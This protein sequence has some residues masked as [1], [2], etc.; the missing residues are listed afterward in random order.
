MNSKKNTRNE[1]KDMEVGLQMLADIKSKYGIK[2]IQAVRF[3]KDS[4]VADKMGDVKMNMD[5]H[6]WDGE[7]KNGVYFEN[8]N[9]SAS[10]KS[11]ISFSLKFQDTSDEKLE[12]LKEGVICSTSFFDD[13]KVYPGFIMVGNT[14]NVGDLLEMSYNPATRKSCQVSM[15]RCL[16]HGF[17]IV[18]WEYD[19]K[20]TWDIITT[21]FPCLGT[22]MSIDDIY[23]KRDLKN[24]V[25]DMM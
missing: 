11:P 12:E 19:K 18:T 7:F 6:G 5:F 10:A 24:L 9:V 4:L 14:R 16:K 21:K 15:P 25:A 22:I 8:K 20:T 17:K 2:G 13:G 1:I 3:M 23:T